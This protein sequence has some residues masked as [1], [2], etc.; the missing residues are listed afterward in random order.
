M[1]LIKFYFLL[2]VKIQILS[3]C[4]NVHMLSCLL[5]AAELPIFRGKHYI[6]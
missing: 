6:I 3:K 2:Q 4:K 5:A 1:Q